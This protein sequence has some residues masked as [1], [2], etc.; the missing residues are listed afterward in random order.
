MDLVEFG[1]SLTSALSLPLFLPF[2][3]SPSLQLF[4][5]SSLSPFFFLL[6]SLPVSFS[7][8]P[9]KSVSVTSVSTRFYIRLDF[10]Q[11]AKWVGKTNKMNAQEKLNCPY[12]Q[13]F[14]K[15]S[16][17]KTN[18]KLSL[19]LDLGPRTV[20]LIFGSVSFSLLFVLFSL[21]IL[22]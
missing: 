1:V 9:Q 6:F 2:S 21:S 13:A 22:V 8:A 18:C 10:G 15:D 20:V 17:L 14:E 3:F 19:P 11:R 12:L 5:F 7:P 4:L 16:K